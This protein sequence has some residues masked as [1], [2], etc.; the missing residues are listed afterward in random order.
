MSGM[1]LRFVRT[2]Q[3]ADGDIDGVTYMGGLFEIFHI[4]G[5]W[6]LV[7]EDEEFEDDDLHE[8]EWQLFQWAKVEAPE[9]LPNA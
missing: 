6:H 7:L 8:L 1:F 4:G 9:C 3:F 2:R 5:K